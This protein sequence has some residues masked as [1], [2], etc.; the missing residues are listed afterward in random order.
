MEL[1]MYLL[2]HFNIVILALVFQ[3]FETE[4]INLKF[5]NHVKIQRYS[6]MSIDPF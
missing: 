3:T 5:L 1:V 2:I 4:L 6:V